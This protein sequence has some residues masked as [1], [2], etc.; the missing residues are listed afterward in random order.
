MKFGRALGLIASLAVVALD[1]EEV[2]N[3]THLSVFLRTL[4]RI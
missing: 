4:M 1:L 2:L 3:L